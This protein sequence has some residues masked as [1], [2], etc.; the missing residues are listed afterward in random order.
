MYNNKTWE[1]KAGK[2][3]AICRETGQPCTDCK[4]CF[5]DIEN[6]MPSHNFVYVC[7]VITSMIATAIAILVLLFKN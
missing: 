5:D 1:Y 7:G 3:I 6:R 2:Y 4:K